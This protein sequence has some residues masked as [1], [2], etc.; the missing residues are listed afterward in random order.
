MMGGVALAACLIPL[1]AI[2]MLVVAFIQA[3]A[4]GSPEL[5]ERLLPP[6]VPAI[7][8]TTDPPRERA[9][10]KQS[11]NFAPIGSRKVGAE[12]GAELLDYVRH[13]HKCGMSITHKLDRCPTC[14]AKLYWE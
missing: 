13:C 1:I 2:G 5:L 6:G 14:G 12:S 4:G 9:R 11:V 8:A 10:N 3:L 7:R